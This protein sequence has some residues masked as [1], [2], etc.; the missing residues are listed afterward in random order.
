[1]SFDQLSSIESGRRHPANNSGNNGGYADDPEFTRLSQDLMNK[2]FHLQGNISKLRSEISLLGTRRDN[3]RL[4]ERVHTLLEES[5][6][7]FKDVGEGVKKVQTWD[8]VTPTQKYSQQKISREFKAALAEFQTLQRTALDKQR[9]SVSAAKAALDSAESPSAADPFAAGDRQHQQLQ[10]QQERIHLAPQDEVDFQEALI[11][12]REEEI[13]QIEEGVGDLNVLFQQ[14]AQIV[15]EQGEQLQTIEDNAINVRD[16][17]RG[18][19]YEL[20]SAARY[21]KNA[22]SK[23]CC[24]LL[25]LAVI[26]TIVLLAVFLG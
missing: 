14:V 3:P 2:L 13:R 26:L 8:D 19:D 7:Q 11:T 15:S 24:L 22:R 10:M 25:I 12:E 6:V 9:A 16:D 5:T 20:R 4:R 1:M 17:V 23:A 21:Q 18:A